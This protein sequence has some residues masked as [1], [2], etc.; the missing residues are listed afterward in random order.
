M[1]YDYRDQLLCSEP[2]LYTVLIEYEPKLYSCINT[3]IKQKK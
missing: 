1:N 2:K 3:S